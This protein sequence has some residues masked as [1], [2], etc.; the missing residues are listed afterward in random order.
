MTAGTCFE[1]NWSYGFC[2]EFL[3]PI[4]PDT[5]YGTCKAALFDILNKFS[6]NYGLSMACGRIFFIYG[7]REHPNR[8]VS[9][10]VISLLNNQ[11]ALCTHGKQIRDFLH[12]EDVAASFVS[13]L[14]SDVEGPVNIASGIPVSVRDLANLIG[15]KVGRENLIRLGAISL[16]TEEAPLV[17][18]DINRLKNEVGWKPNYSL[19]DG[20][21]DS[22]RWWKTESERRNGGG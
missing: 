10:I 4:K 16:P 21:D 6:E 13:L 22:I 9:S 19:N 8:L 7:P 2:S 11:P 12:V 3:T 1:Y 15:K 18:A 5:L 17:V 14:K 20:L